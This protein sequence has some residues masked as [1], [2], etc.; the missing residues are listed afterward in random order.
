MEFKSSQCI[1]DRD[2][3]SP[4][5]QIFLASCNGFPLL[6]NTLVWI[7]LNSTYKIIVYLLFYSDSGIALPI[8]RHKRSFLQSILEVIF[9][10]LKSFASWIFFLLNIDNIYLNLTQYRYNINSDKTLSKFILHAL[11]FY[12]VFDLNVNP[13]PPSVP[14][15]HR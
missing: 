13:F 11:I 8:F 5:K 12:F 2:F 1:G 4:M 14:I 10:L 9:F 7:L 3:A 15:W 6:I